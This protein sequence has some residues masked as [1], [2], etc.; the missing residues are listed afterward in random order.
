MQAK[1]KRNMKIYSISPQQDCSL[2]KSEKK[3][4]IIILLFRLHGCQRKEDPFAYL[5]IYN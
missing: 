3:R 2:Q 1:G 5:I 4:N